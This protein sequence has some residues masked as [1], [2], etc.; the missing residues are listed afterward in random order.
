MSDNF[1]KVVNTLRHKIRKSD[2]HI[3]G[4]ESVLDI[5]NLLVLKLIEPKIKEYGLPKYCRWTKLVELVKSG[6]KEKVNELC[7]EDE[8]GGTEFTIFGQLEK[9]KYTKH[10]FSQPHY[11]RFST[12]KMLIETIDKM[13]FY[14]NDSQI[15]TAYES[16]LKTQLIGRDDGQ[17]F[18]PRGVVQ[19]IVEKLI[20]PRIGEKIYDPCCGTGGFLIYAYLHMKKYIKKKKHQKILDEGT[21]YG[22][23]IDKNVMKLLYLNLLLHGIKPEEDCIK[24]CNT[25]QDNLKK[26]LYDI[27]ITNPPFGKKGNNIFKNG[28]EK[29]ENYDELKKYYGFESSTMPLLTIKHILNIL[30]KNGRCAIV[31]TSGELNN[32]GK[33]YQYIREEL[34]N[35]NTLH[36]VIYLPTGLFEN[37]K[38]INT[39]IL[40]FTK[41]GKTK[42][43]EYNKLELD[44]K[45]NIIETDFSFKVSAKKI[46]KGDYDLGLEKYSENKEFLL[47]NIEYKTLGDVCEFKNGKN[48]KKSE[49]KEGKYPVIGGGKEPTGYH[50]ESNRDKNTILCS[51]SGASA[52][53][54]SRYTSKVW[55]SDCFSI[56]SKEINNDFL[57]YFLQSIQETLYSL[58]KGTGI[59]HVY[60]KN[61]SPIKIPMLKLSDQNEIVK[62]L[63]DIY[64]NSKFTIKDTIEIFNNN[65]I[66]DLLLM[67]KYDVFTTIVNYQKGIISL[68]ESINC[69]ETQKNS[70]MKNIGTFHECT[71]TKLGE[72]CNF[73]SGGKRRV[74]DVT[75]NGKYDF[76][77][78]SIEKM[79]KCDQYDFEGEALIINAVNGSGK[80]NIYY[81]K[82]YSTTSNNI[83]FSFGDKVNTLYMYHYLKS[84][85]N[86]LENGFRG[87]N[88]KKIT[89]DYIGSIKILLPS[90]ITQ[91]KIIKS[92]KKQDKLINILL[93]R[94]NRY[95]YETQIITN[96]YLNN[97]NSK[98]N[99]KNEESEGENNKTKKLKKK[100]VDDSEELRKQ[101]IETI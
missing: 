6:D 81:S 4:R 5:A 68:N 37:A 61:V 69:L 84:N 10:A 75:E 53:H 1:E 101:G 90:I 9:N 14:I 79:Y 22:C 25:L 96:F 51:S 82:K 46:K 18:T 83:H 86:L 17:F 62:F 32:N 21:F 11:T 29:S 87:T 41:G 72:L 98:K 94:I 24:N 43:V 63:D 16:L 8:E 77:T 47:T 88:Q 93:K 100:S 12:F 91:K 19:Y 71:E 49:F 78:C 70:Y 20:K 7:I 64:E 15:G 28:K 33:D 56:D 58:K 97:D 50:E 92:V 73:L 23:D 89:R 35:N 85:I 59:P 80:C 45:G 65:R 66:F 40:F 38:G 2:D 31:V 99:S 27:A 42:R 57:Y 55:A 39:A 74:S 52:G 3:T 34:I 67:K 36:K 60:S 30:K 54:I 48:L 13:N 26:N 44:A 76:I 95:V